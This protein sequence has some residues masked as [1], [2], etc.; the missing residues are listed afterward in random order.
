VQPLASAAAHVNKPTTLLFFISMFRK[1]QKGDSA[2]M[3]YFP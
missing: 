3:G 2:A 1:W